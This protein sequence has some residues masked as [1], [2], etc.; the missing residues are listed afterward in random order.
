MPHSYSRTVLDWKFRTTVACTQGLCRESCTW[1]ICLQPVGFIVSL[2]VRQVRPTKSRDTYDSMSSSWSLGS[3]FAAACE[4]M[5]TG[6]FLS[7]SKAK[8]KKVITLSLRTYTIITL[9]TTTLCVSLGVVSWCKTYR[10]FVSRTK[11]H[12]GDFQVTLEMTKDFVTGFQTANG[13]ESV[14][15]MHGS[16]TY[17]RCFST[18]LPLGFSFLLLLR[19]K[20]D[21][22]I[23]VEDCSLSVSVIMTLI[24]ESEATL[25]QMISC[26]NEN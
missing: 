17:C 23:S 8:G 1:V 18:T 2:S 3:A 9:I 24:T 6:I 11:N 20:K 4:S 26:N 15:D 22:K 25:L 13:R 7:P 21:I 12:S 10:W 16:C 5:N 19:P 14:V